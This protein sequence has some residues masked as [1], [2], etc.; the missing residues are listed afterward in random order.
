MPNIHHTNYIEY[1]LLA[2]AQLPR[3]RYFMRIVGG[4]AVWT[5]IATRFDYK[6]HLRNSQ[7]SFLQRRCVFVV[8]LFCIR[9]VQYFTH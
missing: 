4:L 9:I 2:A 1:L 8:I 3:S 6:F 7:H 5:P